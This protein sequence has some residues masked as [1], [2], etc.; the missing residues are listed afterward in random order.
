MNEKNQ[1]LYTIALLRLTLKEANKSVVQAKGDIFL[2]L[3]QKPGAAQ[4]SRIGHDG[5]HRM[6]TRKM[7]A[8]WPKFTKF[9]QLSSGQV[10]ASGGGECVLWPPGPHLPT[11]PPMTN[12]RPW[13]GCQLWHGDV[14]HGV[15]FKGDGRTSH[16]FSQ[17]FGVKLLKLISP[18]DFC[19]TKSRH[20]TCT[21]CVNAL[22]PRTNLHSRRT[23]STALLQAIPFLSKRVHQ[24]CCQRG[25]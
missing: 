16:L 18:N 22:C 3:R 11:S 8:D 6:R 25:V 1:L 20:R 4:A 14:A 5:A 23:A 19:V 24:Y 15:A 12:T 13:I 7:E 10:L 9:S 17:N 2:M 21:T